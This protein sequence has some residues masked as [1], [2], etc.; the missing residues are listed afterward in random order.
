MEEFKTCA[1]CGENVNIGVQSCPH[2][3]SFAYSTGDCLCDGGK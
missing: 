2:C 1:K 3:G